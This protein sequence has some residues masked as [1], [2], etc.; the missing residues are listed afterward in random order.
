[1]AYCVYYGLMPKDSPG[2]EVIERAKN[3]LTITLSDRQLQTADNLLTAAKLHTRHKSIPD[4]FAIMG[5]RMVSDRLKRA[6]ESLEPGVHQFFPVKL[7]R[8]S[9]ESFETQYYAF[10]TIQIL[11]A[12]DD[13]KSNVFWMPIEGISPSRKMLTHARGEPHW[14]VRKAVVAGK[15]FWREE[16]MMSLFFW[17]EEL[18]ALYRS[19]KMSG[20]RWEKA[21]ED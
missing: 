6:I 19:E 8:K 7:L 20:V 1:M 11:D 9:G 16:K 13:E 17:S 4:H 14:V 15:H 21:E 3:R 2:F 10:H 18:F 5:Q 12:L